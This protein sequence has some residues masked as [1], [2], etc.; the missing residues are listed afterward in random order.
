MVPATAITPLLTQVV[1]WAANDD[2]ITA[3]ALV[4]SYAR[5]AARPDSDVDLVILTPDPQR[6]RAETGWVREMPWDDLQLSVV[7]WVDRDYGLLWSRHLQL[8]NGLEVELGFAP[9]AWAAT[10]PCDPGTLGV[11]RNGCWILLD[12]TGLLNRLAFMGGR[13]PSHNALGGAG[14][15]HCRG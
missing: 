5:G 3:V 8:S 12:P 7:T 9:P 10:D 1:R 11:I 2:R 14:P 15:H 6:F 4:G 13:P